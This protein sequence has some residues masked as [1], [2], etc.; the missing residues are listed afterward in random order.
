MDQHATIL[1]NYFELVAMD[2]LRLHPCLL[3]EAY[4]KARMNPAHPYRS[5]PYNL[6]LLI[7]SALPITDTELNDMA[8]PAMM[9]L[10]NTPKNG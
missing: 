4:T 6:T 8:A 5:R 9:G 7:R 3:G 10:S 2:E 1:F